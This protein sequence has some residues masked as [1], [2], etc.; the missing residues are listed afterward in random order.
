MIEF[1]DW[2]RDKLEISKS[3]LNALKVTKDSLIEIESRAPGLRI[4]HP[5]TEHLI[6]LHVVAGAAFASI[7]DPSTQE[8]ISLVEKLEETITVNPDNHNVIPSSS[9]FG[10]RIFSQLVKGLA[11][12]S[13][14]FE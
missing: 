3:D 11:L 8:Q 10:K 5:R 4:A 6:P 13:Y 1:T 12:D 14:T 9:L 2:I 7:E